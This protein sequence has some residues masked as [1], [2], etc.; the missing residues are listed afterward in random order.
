VNSPSHAPQVLS[1]TVTTPSGTSSSSEDTFYTYQGNWQGYVTNSSDTTVSV[2]DIFTN[3]VSNLVTIGEFPAG[4]GLTPDGTQAYVSN[5]S[6]ANV[7]AI[8]TKSN[9]VSG[10]F[11]ASNTPGA[12]SV[13][14]DGTKVYITNNF[15]T[16]VTFFDILTNTVS[17]IPVA[18]FSFLVAIMPNGTQA[19]V[20]TNSVL[21]VIDIATNVATTIPVGNLPVAVGITPDQTKA[22]AVNYGDGTVSVIDTATNL[23]TAT[24]PVG[25]NP[26]AIAITP[27]GTEAYIV[28]SQANTVS[29]IDI[30]NNV[31][32][33]PINVGLNPSSL[34]ITPDGKRVYVANDGSVSVIDVVSHTVLATIPVSPGASAIAITPDGKKVFIPSGASSENIVSVINTTT[35]TA[36]S[37]FIGEQNPAMMGIT[38]DQAPLARFTQSIAGSG[39]PSI[40]DASA[41]VSPTG[42]IA[43]YF[44]DFGDGNTLHTTNPIVAHTYTIDGTYTVILTVTN[45]AGTSTFQKFN[46]SS[47]PTFY[48]FGASIPLT[49]NGG[50]TAT[51]SH[52]FTLGIAPP[53]NFIGCI[54]K[55]KCGDRNI[56]ALKTHWIASPS[57]NVI[58]YRIYFNGR[59]VKEVS[60]DDHLCFK[61]N[62]KSECSV[63]GIEIS[64][65]NSENLESPLLP[66]IIDCCNM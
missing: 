6:D 46:Y 3:Q 50:P 8:E 17:S 2:I 65:V 7:Y 48:E 26:N 66:L 51:T 60:A 40:F 63:Q 10:F 4:V 47:F 14:P 23:V 54:K 21:S 28:N 43:D 18:D 29:V 42:L 25:L 41:S 34:I 62:L 15:D 61:A 37:I 35:N 58:L 27:D 49:N 13:T 56:F 5:N 24:I 59:L 19:Y 57:E 55:E 38:P 22:L 9:V 32:S 36:S 11:P 39:L 12:V 16:V 20:V 64:A 44:W 31:V 30:A 33:A 1:V 53:S 52:T 45:T